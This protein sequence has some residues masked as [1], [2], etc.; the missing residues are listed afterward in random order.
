MK[1][2]FVKQ[3]FNCRKARFFYNQYNE[4]PARMITVKDRLKKFGSVASLK[5]LPRPI[6]K[7]KRLNQVIIHHRVLKRRFVG[8]KYSRKLLHG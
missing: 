3:K 1:H 4:V 6:N 2:F 7:T 5:Y 8:G